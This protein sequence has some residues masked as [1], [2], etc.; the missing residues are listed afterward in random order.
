MRDP[1]G[2]DAARRRRQFR[3][4]SRC[5]LAKASEKTKTFTCQ[6]PRKA[7]TS[8]HRNLDCRQAFVTHYSFYILD[9]RW[10]PICVVLSSHPPFNAK[11][12]LNGHHWAVHRASERGVHVESKANAFMGT[13]EPKAPQ[14][15]CDSLTEAEIRRVA[16]RWVYRVLP[17]LTY[18]QRHD[19][20]F[21][22][23]WSMAQLE[24]SHNLVFRGSYPSPSSSI[25]TSIST[26]GSW[27]PRR[28]RRSSDGREQ[29]ARRRPTSPSSSPTS[30]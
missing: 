4:S 12:F 8:T 1:I 19:T 29:L 6:E 16:D 14:K 5:R 26:A 21:K 27:A 18:E 10:G 7:T 9:R 23:E 11:V 17:T 20:G 28:S 2:T 15:T 24:V 13:R 30:P 3:I 22:Y 25:V